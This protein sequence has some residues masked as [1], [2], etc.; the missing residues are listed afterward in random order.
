M[1]AALSV[2]TQSDDNFKLSAEES[3]V[4]EFELEAL[5][6]EQ[7]DN[8]P[9]QV[10]F[11]LPESNPEHPENSPQIEF[12]GMEKPVFN[13]QIGDQQVQFQHA[14]NLLTSLEAQD[15][16]IHYQCREGYCGSC[17]VELV[18]GEVHYQEE[19]MAWVND[20]EILLCCC[21]PKSHLKIKL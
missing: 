13:I 6:P 11:Y 18:E 5:Q 19:P 10:E 14:D 2:M 15:V 4:D 1:S 21:I 16:D 17:R 12:D 9:V 20:N 8:Q 7:A 3:A